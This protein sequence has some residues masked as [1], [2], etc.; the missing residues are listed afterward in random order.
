[1]NIQEIER[2]LNILNEKRVPVMNRRSLVGGMQ[3]RIHRQEVRRY[4]NDIRDQKSDLN[5]ELSLLETV[6][7]ND[8]TV[9]TISKD[10][11]SIFCEPKLKKIRDRRGFF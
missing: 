11:T 2:R 7:D 10:N 1:M 9:M 5:K 6:K 3:K 4:R 8:F